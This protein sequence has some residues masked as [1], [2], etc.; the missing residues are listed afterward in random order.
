MFS[1]SLYWPDIVDI[2][3]CITQVARVR[4]AAEEAEDP[5][6]QAAR[7]SDAVGVAVRTEERHF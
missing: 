7:G 6:E 1:S 4:M 3:S 2:E 5:V